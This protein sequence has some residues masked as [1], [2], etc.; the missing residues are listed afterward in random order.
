MVL[1]NAGLAGVAGDV[2]LAGEVETRSIAVYHDAAALSYGT[3]VDDGA[4][5]HIHAFTACHTY[6]AAISR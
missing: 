2:D 4:A 6:A 1:R 3:V 5:G